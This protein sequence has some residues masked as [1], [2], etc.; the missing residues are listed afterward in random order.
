MEFKVGE[1]LRDI[2][3]AVRDGGDKFR[4]MI[5]F[6]FLMGAGLSVIPLFVNSVI[7]FPS[8]IS[9]PITGQVTGDYDSTGNSLVTYKTE[10]GE[11][12][13]Y[14]AY[15]KLPKEKPVEVCESAF[16]RPFLCAELQDRKDTFQK[17]FLSFLVC[18]GFLW[19][20]FRKAFG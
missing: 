8:F 12:R 4:S 13:E 16:G 9:A 19:W 18:T 15:A 10:S 5:L 17:S 3:E 20:F 11:S 7:F 14:R 1:F 6:I 2:Y